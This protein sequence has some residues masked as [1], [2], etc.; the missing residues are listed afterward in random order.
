[1]KS[2]IIILVLI[3]I[4]VFS[5]Y[6]SGGF[7]IFGYGFSLGSITGNTPVT[8]VRSNVDGRTYQVKDLPDKQDA[9]DILAKIRARLI[10]LMLHMENKYPSDKNVQRMVSRFNPD[11]LQE[12]GHNSGITTYTANKGAKIVYCLRSRKNKKQELHRDINL[13]MMVSLHEMAHLMDP[14]HNPNHSGEFSDYFKMIL[15]EA[16]DI[17]IFDSFDYSN[18]GGVEYCGMQITSSPI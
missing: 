15:K 5:I 11:T 12:G 9:A 13:L 4:G 18:K 10:Q 8:M 6:L 2:N 14:S 17:N 3:F 1:M 16:K 7:Q